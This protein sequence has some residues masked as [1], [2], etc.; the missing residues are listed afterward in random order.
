MTAPGNNNY[1]ISHFYYN[2]LTPRQLNCISASVG[3]LLHSSNTHNTHMSP[4]QCC[5][6]QKFHKRRE[7]VLVTRP[8]NSI[9][10]HSLLHPPASRETCTNKAFHGYHY[11]LKRT[12]PTT[13]VEIRAVRDSSA[14]RVGEKVG[15][16]CHN[17]FRIK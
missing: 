6:S 8:G 10:R 3:S 7:C 4:V 11:T 12:P 2:F 14:A 16:W 9:C 5:E 17:Q 13:T 1:K 15:G